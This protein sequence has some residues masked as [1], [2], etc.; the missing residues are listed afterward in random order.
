MQQGT[1]APD[2]VKG[3]N[4]AA[5]GVVATVADGPWLLHG[6]ID[7]LDGPVVPVVY[8]PSVATNAESA[9]ILD[10][11][12]MLFGRVVSRSVRIENE[13]GSEWLGDNL[14][15]VVTATALRID[16]EL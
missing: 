2:W 8:L 4:N 10:P 3:Y 9:Q 6:L 5:G 15:E 16:E 14:G 7:A 13:T 1:P 12:R 11:N